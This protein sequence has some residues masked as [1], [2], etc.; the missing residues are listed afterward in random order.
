MTDKKDIIKE[1][2]ENMPFDTW[3]PKGE[4]LLNAR[5]VSKIKA[6]WEELR[7]EFG[8]ELEF[9]RDFTKIKKKNWIKN[10]PI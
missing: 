7:K 2:I 5:E 10:R 8:V 6:R 9:N 1:S 3:M 4:R